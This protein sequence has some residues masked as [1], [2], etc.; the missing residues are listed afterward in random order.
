MPP[1]FHFTADG[2]TKHGPVSLEELKSLVKEGKLRSTDMV[3]QDGTPRWQA[4]REIAGLFA[5]VSEGTW[6]YTPDGKTRHGPVNMAQLQDLARSG[7]LPPDAMVREGTGK[8]QAAREIAG[9]FAAVS[10]GTWLYTPDGKTKHGPVT[11]AQLQDLARSGKL[12]PNAM[13]REGTGKWQAAREI[14]GLFAAVSVGT[15]LYT[16]DGK[17][18]HGPVTMAQPQDLARSGKLPPDAMV[19]EGTGKWQ[20]AREIA[21]LFAAVSEGTWLYT[22][23]GKTKHG[24]VTMA[25]LQD[26]ARSGKLLPNAMVREGTGKWQAAREVAGLF[27]AESVGTWL[28]TPD[29]KTR[30]GPVTMAQPQ[31]LARSGKLP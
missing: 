10:E 6:L 9:L 22:P 16:P 5:A 4:A 20:A 15:W 8:W 24:P 14:A 31:D 27:F 30:H 18:R 11:M 28:Y 7:K 19:R 26:L 25:Q 2:K 12:L 29:G 23:D 21:G 13:V 1:T 17:T 3:R